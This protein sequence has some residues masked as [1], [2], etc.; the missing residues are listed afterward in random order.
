MITNLYFKN[1]L[2]YVWDADFL[3]F[4]ARTSGTPDSWKV[5]YNSAFVELKN[6]G[7]W[8]KA[9]SI[10][11]L[12]GYD[13]ADSL[14]DL[15]RLVSAIPHNSPTFTAKDGYK[16]GAGKYIDMNYNPAIDGVGW[17]LNSAGIYVWINEPNT[18]GNKYHVGAYSTVTNATA[19]AADISSGEAINSGFVALGIPNDLVGIK[20]NSRTSPSNIRA[21]WNDTFYNLSAATNTITPLS[22]YLLTLNESGTPGNFHSTAEQSFTYVGAALSDAEAQYLKTFCLWWFN[23]ISALP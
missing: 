9:D 12:A 10:Y 2:S 13:G 16:G 22:L 6:N 4:W 20:G 15:K 19:I 23:E 11:L 8:A 3:A 21:F 1:K 14:I 18:G 7:I 17:T 5:A